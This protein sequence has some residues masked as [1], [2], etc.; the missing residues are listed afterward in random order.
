VAGLAAVELKLTG[1]PGVVRVVEG[2]RLAVGGSS[3]VTVCVA[4]GEVW[5]ASLVTVSVTVYVPG[6]A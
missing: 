1:E 4:T 3:T 5:P 2:V 6:F